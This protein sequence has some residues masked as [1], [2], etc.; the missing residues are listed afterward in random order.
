[1]KQKFDYVILGSD[2]V[3]YSTAVNKYES[4]LEEDLNEIK[5]RLISEGKTDVELIVFK[6]TVLH[7]KSYKVA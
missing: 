1:M 6:A 3:W 5:K 7:K 2:D 4:D